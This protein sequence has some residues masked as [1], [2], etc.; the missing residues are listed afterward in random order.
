VATALDG[1]RRA[2]ADVSLLDLREL[3]LPVYNHDEESVA[4]PGVRQ[5][6][7]EVR[8]ADAVIVG[9][10]VYQE[11]CSGLVKNALDHLNR[12]LGDHPPL[13]GGRVVGLVSVGG[14]EMSTG[15]VTTLRTV[16]RALGA[17]V[18]PTYEVIGT[19][20][21]DPGGELFDLMAR[22]RLRRLG[23]HVV[24]SAGARRLQESG[25][26]EAAALLGRR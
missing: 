3:R 6:I 1:A 12:L 15:A 13:L 20:S 7:T 16:C 9:S 2:G 8:A 19:A 11:S 24:E 17:W 21:F 26:T 10:P 4:D 22:D 23:R 5:L 25:V 14:D 18:L